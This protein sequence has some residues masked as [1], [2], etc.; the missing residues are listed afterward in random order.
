MALSRAHLQRCVAD[1]LRARA[2]LRRDALLCSSRICSPSVV[3]LGNKTTTLSVDLC[4]ARGSTLPTAMPG[5]LQMSLE[6]SHEP[7]MTDEVL[8]ALAGT[9][10][11]P[12][13]DATV[14][15]GGHAEALLV[16]FP[17]RTLVGLDQD[18]VAIAAARARL[19]RFDGRVQLFHDR[20][21]RIADVARRAGVDNGVSAV[22][23]DLGVSS[24]QLDTP[25]RGFSYHQEGPL[26]MR[27]NPSA[28]VS[29]GEYL[30]SATESAL[31][32][33][34]YVHG[35]T[36]FARKI[37][38]AIVTHR[39]LETTSQLADLVAEVIPVAAR[40]RGHPARRVFQALRVAVNEELD[41][42]GPAIDDA[43]ALLA[44]SGRIVVLSY[45]S[46]EDR[47]VKNHLLY[48]AT[49]GCTCPPGLP[50]V[51]GAVPTLRLLNRGAR[52]AQ[53]EEL[54]RNPRAKSARFRAAERLDRVETRAAR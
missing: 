31:S 50:C 17:L 13:I 21:D 32:E 51:C 54:A 42:L 49:G 4:P 5:G 2:C 27:M 29:A 26:D 52:K 35:E 23:F 45:H 36:R 28:G 53:P 7:V 20:F 16:A 10:D 19:E 1:R 11:L 3:A 40:R 41:I 8:A 34:F 33:L 48:G 37:A 43:I 39:P 25:E 14:G 44:P 46:G 24:Y 30:N 38:A 22:L 12:M 9:P 15:G 18:E 6:F 47:I